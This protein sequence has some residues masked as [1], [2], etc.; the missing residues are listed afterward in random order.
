MDFGFSL[1]GTGTV[2]GIPGQ[3]H[4]ETAAVTAPLPVFGLRGLWELAP[5]WFLDAQ[6]QYF[7]LK[8]DN[9]DGRGD[10]LPGWRDLDVQ[11]ALW[12]WERATTRLSPRW[13]STRTAF[14][15]NLKWRYSG[16]QV[17]ITG[18]F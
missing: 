13:M 1:S 12:E 5:N 7:Q 4:T 17:F 9:I 3:A 14:D 15:G 8:I 16:A 10:R 6:A 11:Q 2:N 18:S